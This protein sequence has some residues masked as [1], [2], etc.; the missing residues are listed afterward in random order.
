[1]VYDKDGSSIMRIRK[2]KY[3]KECEAENDRLKAIDSG[4]WLFDCP[5]KP[6]KADDCIHYDRQE[7][8]NVP[9][10]AGTPGEHQE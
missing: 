1:M 4:I 5:S 6:R 7:R 9:V 8:E 10:S 2:C 3:A